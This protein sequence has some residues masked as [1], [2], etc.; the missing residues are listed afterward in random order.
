ML[1][2]RR[3]ERYRRCA[4]FDA[5]CDASAPVL[6]AHVNRDAGLRSD[7]DVDPGPRA[8]PDDAAGC[9]LRVDLCPGV[10]RSGRG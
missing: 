1:G 6:R 4:R 5:R 8:D 9:E 10:L 3:R 7:A 2:R